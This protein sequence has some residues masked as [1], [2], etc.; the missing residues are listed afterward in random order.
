MVEEAGI[1]VRKAIVI[2]L[3]DVGSKQIVQG[4]DLPAPWQFQRYFQP[5]GVLVEHR[6]DDVNK[7]LI[8][9]KQPVPSGEQISFEP[10]LAL[11]LTEHRVQHASGGCEE[12]VIFYFSG[13]PLTVGDFKN[14]AQEI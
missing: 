6:I 8:A 10:T 13:V 12:F 4:G 1:L 5:L 14:R 7:G 3:P 2:L 11:V 9:V